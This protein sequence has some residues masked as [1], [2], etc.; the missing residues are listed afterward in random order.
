[1][2]T[3]LGRHIRTYTRYFV[4]LAAKPLCHRVHAPLYPDQVLAPSSL[5]QPVL[6]QSLSQIFW[7]RSLCVCAVQKKAKKKKGENHHRSK[8]EREHAKMAQFT[9][10]YIFFWREKMT[11]KEGKG[12]IFLPL[13]FSRCCQ[14][15]PAQPLICILMEAKHSFFAL[16]GV[17]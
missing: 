6:K 3:C 10:H 13:S 4:I 2:Y 14:L 11:E 16:R 5:L 17:F 8:Q 7:C 9:R 15:S 1:M 12:E